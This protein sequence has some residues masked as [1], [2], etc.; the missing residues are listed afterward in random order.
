[1]VKN[2]FV[3]FRLIAFELIITGI[4]SLMIAIHQKYETV[5]AVSG[6]IIFAGVVFL[7]FAGAIR[8]QP[9]IS[10]KIED[11]IS[12]RYNQYFL[13][14][15]AIFLLAFLFTVK[16][17]KELLVALTPAL[18]YLWL[19]GLE[20]IWFFPTNW[21][22]SSSPQKAGR[23]WS[24]LL[25][26]LLVY[27]F[28][29]VPSHVPTLLDGVLWDQTFE[30]VVAT[31]LIPMVFII[32]WGFFSNRKS[33][34]LLFGLLLIK[35][36]ISSFTPQSGLGI[37]IYKDADSYAAG[38]WEESY[39]T[40]L[41]PSYTS[42]MQS[43]YHSIREMPVEWVNDHFGFN[44]DKFWMAL[45]LSGTIHIPD[46]GRF[47]L[48]A[49]GEAET[50]LEI[51]DLDSHIKSLPVIVDNTNKLSEKDYLQL[52]DIKNFEIQGIILFKR[53]AEARL[54]PALVYPDGSTRSVFE[55]AG[56]WLSSENIL[57]QEQSTYFRIILNLLSLTFAGFL[58]LGFFV[59][60]MEMLGRNQLSAADIYIVQTSI[61]VFYIAG[62]IPKPQL[63]YFLA[64]LLA[65]IVLIKTIDHKFIRQETSFK[66]YLVSVGIIFLAVFMIMDISSL[67]AMSP[68]PAGQDGLE[69]QNFARH[70]F[71]YGDTFL[72]Q[73]PPRAYKILFPYLV[74]LL[75]LLFGQS[76][77][78]QL[79][80]NS[81][82]AILSSALTFHLAKSLKLPS[83]FSFSISI[84]L[85]FIL[86][87][88]A[89]FIFY[90][91]FGLIEPI[92]ILC[93]LTT[94]YFASTRRTAWLFVSGI[95]TVLFRLDYIGLA[96]AAILLT[97]P[98]ITGTV[99][100]AWRQLL[101]WAIEQWK[102][103][104][105]YLISLCIFPFTIILGYFLLIP[106]YMLNAGDTR[107]SSLQTMFE[108]LI[109]V[110]FGD[111]PI[112]LLARFAESPLHTLLIAIPLAGGFFIALAAIFFRKGI[113]SKL[114]LRWA[115][116]I[117]AVLPPYIAVQPTGYF[118]RFSFSLL[119]LDLIMIGLL[120]HF[121]SSKTS[122]TE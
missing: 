26:L 96:F 122:R 119:P 41:T 16:P 34:I 84:S 63:P 121:F 111:T 120:A 102:L 38:I 8:S 87:F 71:V 40:W 39:H 25:S 46:D 44:F 32:N 97:A 23:S 54:E 47:V 106:N 56:V 93:L 108:S 105:A 64:G 4:I 103:I 74:G 13:F 49:R 45:E 51:I 33:I 86:C 65:V 112:G 68:F 35:I 3:F 36:L 85:L 62:M 9:A 43:P 37:R 80:L 11:F 81:W 48:L 101:D 57:T 5:L 89:S 75:H 52:P 27:G 91:R 88:P 117:P 90:Y 118:P 55:N 31:L 42:V 82:S 21:R 66:S 114:D 110:A 72:A 115:L 77:S 113:F 73:T 2:I 98:A 79:F 1:M 22:L 78:A 29:L 15:P 14:S 83:K 116:L 95:L 20:F 67:K 17:G 19:V 12:S 50:N 61:L 100:Q 30:F 107:Q 10:R 76:T 94:L 92:A 18:L 7:F 28:L 60:L 53:F 69:Y 70:I 59:G 58:S 24:S 109:R 6:V 99:R 104:T